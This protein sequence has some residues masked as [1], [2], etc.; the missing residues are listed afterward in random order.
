MTR[1]CGSFGIHQEL[2]LEDDGKPLTSSALSLTS[3][4]RRSCIPPSQTDQLLTCKEIWILSHIY[5]FICSVSHPFP[6][7][8]PGCQLSTNRSAVS[9]FI[10]IIIITVNVTCHYRFHY[11]HYYHESLSQAPAPP[12]ILT[13]ARISPDG[14]SGPPCAMQSS[15][16]RANCE[17]EGIFV[18]NRK[19]CWVF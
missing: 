3:K 17:L 16:R 5:V 15:T 18:K 4:R 1:W 8:W 11:H 12:L 2:R 9:L 14:A 19:K 7:G 13:W 10:I 6:I